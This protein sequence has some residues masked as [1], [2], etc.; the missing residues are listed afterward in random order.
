MLIPVKSYSLLLQLTYKKK[1]WLTIGRDI[2]L[3]WVVNCNK[4]DAH[5]HTPFNYIRFP[6]CGV[7]QFYWLFSIFNILYLLLNIHLPSLFTDWIEDAFES[8][9][10]L[11]I[12][13]I[14]FVFFLWIS[15]WKKTLK[16]ILFLYLNVKLVAGITCS[17]K[18]GERIIPEK[19]LLKMLKYHH[20][21]VISP[22]TG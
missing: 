18:S 10:W 11:Y 7:L 21:K 20:R 4:Q 12:N 6:Q 19:I 1:K 2:Y 22:R 3:P 14:V 5:T 13:S 15:V 9:Y 8:S 16:T 17:V